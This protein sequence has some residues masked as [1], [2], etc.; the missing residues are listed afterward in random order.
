[1]MLLFARLAAR[2]GVERLIV[3]GALLF[4]VRAVLWTVA[5]SPL[6]LIAFTS[7]GGHRVRAGAGGD[8]DL[9][10]GARARPPAG[11]GAGPVRQRRRSRSG[12][13]PGAVVAGQVAA[14]GGLW[15]VYPVGAVGAAVGAVMV[16]AA[17]GRRPTGG[18][19]TGILIAK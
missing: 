9:R 3:A 7:L 18:S 1:M 5:G 17:I 13:S 19:P 15:A 2:I 12:P 4:V 16:W 10:G 8:H 6:A 11:D 14:V